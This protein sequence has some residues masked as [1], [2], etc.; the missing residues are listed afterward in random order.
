MKPL[1]LILE[2]NENDEND[3]KIINQNFIKGIDFQKYNF[4]IMFENERYVFFVK[5]DRVD[6]VR[7][8]RENI[9]ENNIVLKIKVLEYGGKYCDEIIVN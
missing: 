9:F 7:Q 4:Q 5:E 6:V 2:Y 3:V 1:K 8:F